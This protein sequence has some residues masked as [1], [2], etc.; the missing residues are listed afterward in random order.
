M[1]G[2]AATPDPPELELPVLEPDAEPPELE[3]EPEP[4]LEA[5]LVEPPDAVAPELEP[6]DAEL[7]VA[8]GPE[9]VTEPPQAQS[10]EQRLETIQ[11]ADRT[12]PRPFRSEAATGQRIALA[13]HVVGDPWEY[14]QI[15]P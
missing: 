3:L 14:L 6:L 15:G 12:I 5:E 11:R 8:A 2:E 13:V 7:P 10:K 9:V 1:A 4:E